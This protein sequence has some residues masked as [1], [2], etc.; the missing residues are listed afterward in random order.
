MRLLITA[1]VGGNPVDLAIDAEDGARVSDLAAVLAQAF[2]TT[3]LQ[4][5]A[6]GPPQ[7]RVVGADRQ[8]D[9]GAPVLHLPDGP[10]PPDQPLAQ[11]A[12]R[13]GVGLGVG[14]PVPGSLAEPRGLAEVRLVSGPGAGTVMQYA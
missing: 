10:L 1:V 5:A 2:P 13:H 12:I 11:S 8:P 7:L 6:S 9:A 14:A 3:A 4:P